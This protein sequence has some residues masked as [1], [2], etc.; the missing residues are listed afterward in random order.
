MD[1]KHR[2]FCPI[3]LSLEIF[4]NRWT[5]LILRDMIF[6]GRRH[7]RELMQLEEGISTNILADRLRKLVEE[8]ILTRAG[9]PSHK[10]K[11]V[12]SLT[13][14]GIAL[15]PVL[16]QI[17][18]WGRRYLPASGAGREQARVLEEGGPPLWDELMAELRA[19]HVA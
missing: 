8:G 10:Q 18:V 11:L 3:N 16:A 2:S 5:L 12:Y 17:G 13:E 6:G 4:G 1:E 15:V 9:D 7:F 19:T 14:K